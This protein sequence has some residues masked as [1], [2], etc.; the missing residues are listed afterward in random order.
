M[1]DLSDIE[2]LRKACEEAEAW[3]EWH[4]CVYSTCYRM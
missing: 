1:G 4:E 3:S 2:R